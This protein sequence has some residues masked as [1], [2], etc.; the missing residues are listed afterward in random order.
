MYHGHDD[1]Y[2]TLLQTDVDENREKKITFIIVGVFS[3]M[4]VVTYSF[5]WDIHIWK[6]NR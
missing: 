3:F 2:V 6:V 1:M 5:P 4:N